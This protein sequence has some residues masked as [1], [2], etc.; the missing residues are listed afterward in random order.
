LAP[1]RARGEPLA[2]E[3]IRR[4]VVEALNEAASELTALGGRPVRF[5]AQAELPAGVA[6]ES[7]IARTSCVPTRPNLHDFFNG[8][9]W[10]A[11]PALKRRL[12]A[13]QAEQLARAEPG[14]P[15]GALRDALTLF[16]EN[17]ALLQ[18][19]PV[20]IDALRGRDWQALFVAHR[21]AWVDARLELFGHAL[22]EKLVRP[23]KAITAHVLIVPPG[24]GP[25]TTQIAEALTPAWLATKPFL[26]LPLLGVPGWW[27]AN[28]SP[29]FY[30]DEAVFR[31]L[32]TQ[33]SGLRAAVPI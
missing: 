28:A 17:V 12:N 8:L 24:R 1:W 13:L 16:D 29:D 19:P 21:A 25:M 15:R 30:R 6:Y 14:T 23:R 10:L 4:G 32:S 9:A 22:I 18:A 26:P 27:A 20:L 5:V 7:F 33:N 2:A 11:H 31:P 3:A